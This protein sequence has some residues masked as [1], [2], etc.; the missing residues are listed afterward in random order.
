MAPKPSNKGKSVQS[1]QSAPREGSSNN[2]SSVP[3]TAPEAA[4]A[5]TTS[6]ID[7]E[8]AAAAAADDIADIS[9]LSSLTTSGSRSRRRSRRSNESASNDAVLQLLTGLVHSFGRRLDQLESSH[10]SYPPPTRPM[11]PSFTEV[12]QPTTPISL[13]RDLPPHLHSRMDRPV[14]S[15]TTLPDLSPT[16]N[17]GF[18]SGLQ[19]LGVRFEDVVSLSK[20]TGSSSMWNSPSMSRSR[21]D[22]AV[23]THLESSPAQP[24]TTPPRHSIEPT[25]STSVSALTGRVPHC[26]PEFL[27]HFNGDSTQL[28]HF[29][30]R[31][32]DVYRLDPDPAWGQAVLRT[33]PL[34]M[35]GDA[36][37]WHAG[38]TDTEAASLR[39]MTAWMDKMREAFPTNR[40]EQGRLARNRRWVPEDEGASAYF[41]YKLRLLRAVYGQEHTEQNLAH[42]ILEGFPATFRVMLRLPRSNIT[43]DDVRREI[44]EC[45]P[46]WREV[47]GQ[48][49][50]SN[51]VAA[52]ASGSRTSGSSSKCKDSRPSALGTSSPAPRSSQPKADPSSS[53][54]SKSDRPYVPLSATYDPSRIIPATGSEVRKYRRPDTDKVITL[55]RP[56]AACGEKHFGFEHEHLKS[57]GQVRTAIALDDYP[58]EDDQ[59]EGD[60]SSFGASET[61]EN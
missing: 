6:A 48:S 49:R 51:T 28:E 34:V 9:S 37:V 21:S 26:K 22:T 11:T 53:S 3:S 10:T 23:A 47:H 44:C 40:Y 2:P 61:T 15:N 32:R 36:A 17:A 8:S 54:M 45:E 4:P 46:M 12:H 35:E 59:E 7:P 29:L 19:R 58:E 18:Q 33:M 30:G 43:L 41:F 31:A 20:Q 14:T 16:E 57:R 60:Q 13:G 39:T 25:A 24:S 38:L 27:G 56:C 55:D 52:S 42:D 1:E 5:A 50:S